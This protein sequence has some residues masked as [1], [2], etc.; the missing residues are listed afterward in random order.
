MKYYS[1]LILATMLTQSHGSIQ[2]PSRS[3]RGSPIES[4]INTRQLQLSTQ[5]GCTE[6]S[7]C[8]DNYF[9]HVADGDC[10][11]GY[12]VG[13]CY[14][15]R[16]SRTRSLNR[17]SFWEDIGIIWRLC[18]WSDPSAVGIFI[19]WNYAWW[20][21]LRWVRIAFVT[22]L[23]KETRNSLLYSLT[24]CDGVT[25]TDRSWATG[26]GVNVLHQGACDDKEIA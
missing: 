11:S 10:L 17:V 20:I 2:N 24:G 19:F 15:M 3:I 26:A 4:N 9:C 12:V 25:Y 8:P 1:I 6:N 21:V 5:G 22:L 16:V 13:E 7:E 18:S 14:E 23:L